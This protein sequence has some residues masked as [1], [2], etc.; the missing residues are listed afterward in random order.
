M[1]SVVEDELLGSLRRHPAVTALLPDLERRVIAGEIA[2]TQ[3]ARRLLKAAGRD[4]TPPK[5]FRWYDLTLSMIDLEGSEIDG[6]AGSFLKEDLDYFQLRKNPS[7]EG[8]Q[9]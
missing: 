1:W 2:P 3:A 4:L 8:S 5:G 6:E 7:A 9:S